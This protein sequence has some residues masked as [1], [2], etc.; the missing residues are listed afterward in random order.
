MFHRRGP[1][2]SIELTAARWLA[3]LPRACRDARIP[4]IALAGSIEPGVD[5]GAWE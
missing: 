1:A 2:G 3:E 5:F 4:C